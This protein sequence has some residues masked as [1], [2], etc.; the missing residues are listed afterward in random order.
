[1][2]VEN[3]DKKGPTRRNWEPDAAVRLDGGLHAIE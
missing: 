2:A 3:N 1:M